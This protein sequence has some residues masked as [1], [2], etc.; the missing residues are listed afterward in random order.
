MLAMD[1]RCKTLSAEADGYVRAEACGMMQ[2]EVMDAH[3]SASTSPST[4]RDCV[5]IL[6]GTAVNQ[7]SH[8]SKD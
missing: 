8:I 6:A 2:I 4:A 7:V 3:G 5:G 1:G